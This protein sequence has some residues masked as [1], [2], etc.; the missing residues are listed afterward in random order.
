M[1]RLPTTLLLFLLLTAGL[2]GVAP[3]YRVVILT[4][5]THDDGNSLIRYLYYGDL[6]ETEAIIV[7]NQLPDF[8]HDDPGPWDKVQGILD[9]YAAEYPQ[10]L[11]HNDGLPAPAHYRAVTRRGRG[12]IPIIWLTNEKRFE[13]NIA[14][15]QVAT[16]WGDIRFDDWIGE[17]ENP[18]GLPKDSPGSDYLQEVF[19]R[20]DDRPIFVQSWGGPI[21]FIQALY[22]YRQRVP[23]EKF[24]ALLDKLH[25]YCILFQDITFDYLVNLDLAVEHL[26]GNFGTVRSTYDGPRVRPAQLLY[27]GG[28]FW[29]YVWSNDPDW[30]KPMT[31]AEVNGH[32]PLSNLYD[33]GGEGD[34]PAFL[35]LISAAFGLNDPLDP[36]QG[37]WGGRFQPMGA[38]FP[39]GYFMTCGLDDTELTRWVQAN[40][41]SFFNR[42]RTSVHEPG[43]VNREPVVVLNG[44]R[45]PRVLHIRGEPGQTYRL[46]AAASYDPDRQPLRFRWFYYQ[47]ASRY[48][49]KFSF[50]DPTAA[51]QDV[52]L[53]PNIGDGNIH[54]VLEA[55]D[56]GSP[57]LTRYR[58]VILSAE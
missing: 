27:D 18:H 11:R 35:Y 1:T 5:M 7:T 49:G 55:T 57:P 31:A 53:P 46:D 34:T 17:G 14:G 24:Q 58:R 33:H 22:R 41:H 54:L 6:F 51:V 56:S 9:A 45:S 21:T 44:E 23:P 47:D 15:R 3:P 52:L 20:D 28:H 43:A 32:G 10:L 48:L 25:V 40:R 38:P 4:D 39:E 8:R 12:A 37:S 2:S 19:D 42:L 36:T 26:C 30:R 16:T 29:K 13:G 50:V